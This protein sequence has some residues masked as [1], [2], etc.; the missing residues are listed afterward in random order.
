MVGHAVNTNILSFL[1]GGDR[2]IDSLK[3]A[4]AKLARPYLKTKMLK[5]RT[6]CKRSIFL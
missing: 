5:K 2:R 6:L 1:G 3:L 4:Q